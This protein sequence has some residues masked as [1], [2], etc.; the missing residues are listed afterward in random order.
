MYLFESVFPR[1]SGVPLLLTLSQWHRLKGVSPT[2][3]LQFTVAGI[4]GTRVLKEILSRCKPERVLWPP[5]PREQL[6]W[7]RF[8]RIYATPSEC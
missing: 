8:G 1:T 5:G 4:A 3:Y 6:Q 2:G 7:G